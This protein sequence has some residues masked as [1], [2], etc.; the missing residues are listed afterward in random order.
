ML[1]LDQQHRSATPLIPDSCFVVPPVVHHFLFFFHADLCPPPLANHPVVLMTA[2]Y[3]FLE[4]SVIQ[5]Q[6]ALR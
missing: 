5:A 4:V 2:V 6:M 1:Q 3:R